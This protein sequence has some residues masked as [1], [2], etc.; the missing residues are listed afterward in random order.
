M[1]LRSLFYGSACELA[2]RVL[3]LPEVC[4]GRL[5]LEMVPNETDF[6]SDPAMAVVLV[7]VAACKIGFKGTDIQPE[8]KCKAENNCNCSLDSQR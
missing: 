1:Q 6:C 3:V 4:C 5:L 8:E 7:I 2:C